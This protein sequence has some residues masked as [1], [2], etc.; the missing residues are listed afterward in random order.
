MYI[1]VNSDVPECLFL[2]VTWS[3]EIETS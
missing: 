1:L 2:K 3:L